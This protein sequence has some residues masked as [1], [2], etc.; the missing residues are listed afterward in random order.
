MSEDDILVLRRHSKTILSC[1]D[2]YFLIKQSIEAIYDYFSRCTNVY[3]GDLTTSHFT[4]AKNGQV[5]HE[6]MAAHCLIDL[7]RTTRFLRGVH[8]AIT[9]QSKKTDQVRVLYAGCGPYATL[10]TP[11]LTLFQVGQVQVV[12]V[13]INEESLLKATKLIQALG[14]YDFIAD[15]QKADCTDPHISFSGKFDVIVSETMQH[16]LTQECQVPLTRNLVRFLT[17]EGTFVPQCIDL[18]LFAAGNL[19]VLDPKESERSFCGNIYSLD[20][21]NVPDPDHHQIIPIPEDSPEH[22]EIHTKIHLHGD[23]ILSS[24]DCG[25]TVPQRFTTMGEKR[26]REISFTYREGS[27]MGLEHE[28]IF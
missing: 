24:F 10:I 17:P 25:L 12:L 3:A 2:D 27:R 13:D 6:T 11:L 28:L 20:F 18:N 23:H 16:G 7:L 21:R 19:N 22:L 15:A 1:E 26:P 5:V 8:D 14:L 9:S 4:P